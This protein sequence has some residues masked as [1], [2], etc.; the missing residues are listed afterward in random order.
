M[1]MNIQSGAPADGTSSTGLIF[2]LVWEQTE[3]Y[4]VYILQMLLF[5]NAINWDFQGK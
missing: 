2:G 3:A 4:A 1:K 5:A